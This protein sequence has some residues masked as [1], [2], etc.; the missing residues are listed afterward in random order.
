MYEIVKFTDD[1]GRNVEITP[2]DVKRHLCANANDSEV[3]LFLELC[4]AQR[5]NPFIKD[6]YLV[7]YGNAPASII[8]GKEVFTKRANA[9]PNFEGMEHGVV[10]MRKGPQG[11]TVDKR[12]G[13]AVYKAAGETL[14][15]GWAR[16]F[17]KGKKPFYCELALEEYSTGKSNWAKMPAVMI[18]K[19]AQVAALRLAFPDQF[20]GLYAAEEM[21]NAGAAIIEQDS[22]PAPAPI[23][24]VEFVEMMSEAQEAALCEQAAMLADMRGVAFDDVVRSLYASKAMKAAEAKDN[25]EL[26]A[27]Q[28]DVALG[29]LSRWIDQARA[30]AQEAA[31]DAVTA[32]MERAKAASLENL[33]DEDTAF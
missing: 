18:D 30:K 27:E 3:A 16:V 22:K 11:V 26:T 28:A 32:A 9:N 23:P 20:Q 19:C 15:G 5:L 7:K 12:E 14:L 10:F 4:K 8:T 2:E 33:A 1:L 21:G 31:P 6:A 25:A 24:V 13:A 29:V 17:V